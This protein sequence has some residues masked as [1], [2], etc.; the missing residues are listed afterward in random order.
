ML[1]GFG[2]KIFILVSDN[3]TAVF[4][5]AAGLLRFLFGGNNEKFN[6]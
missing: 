1:N 3:D 6:H 2:W 5:S 4:R